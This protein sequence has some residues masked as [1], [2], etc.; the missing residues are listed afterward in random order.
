MRGRNML[1]PAV[2]IANSTQQREI[3]HYFFHRRVVALRIEIMLPA[4]AQRLG[5]YNRRQR[6][7]RQRKLPEFCLRLRAVAVLQKA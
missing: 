3:L 7:R 6:A 1:H 4:L 2:M 5:I